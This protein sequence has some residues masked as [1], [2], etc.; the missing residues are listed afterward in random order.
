MKE[1]S[2]IPQLGNG[3][4]RFEPRSSGSSILWGDNG[5]YPEGG[6]KIS[7]VKIDEVPGLVS[8]FSAVTVCI[9]TFAVIGVCMVKGSQLTDLPDHVYPS[10]S[11][12]V[13]LAGLP[14]TC[15]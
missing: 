1:L 10:L 9:L 6:W 4:K 3:E 11:S 2:K 15:R 8:E 12:D 14:L 13:S 7:C 5:T